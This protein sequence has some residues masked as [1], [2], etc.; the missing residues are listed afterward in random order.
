MYSNKKF[1]K[2]CKLCRG[3][4][5]KYVDQAVDCVGKVNGDRGKKYVLLEEMVKDTQDKKILR[6]E[7]MGLL[8]AGRD[9]TAV[10][11]GWAVSIR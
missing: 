4:V 6:D 3:L 8:V 9:T 11:L 7:A 5:S 10:T 2:A 1:L